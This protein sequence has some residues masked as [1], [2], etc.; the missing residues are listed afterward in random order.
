MKLAKIRLTYSRASWTH[1]QFQ[2]AA[3][4]TFIHQISHASMFPF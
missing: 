2:T 3:I 1:E 4:A